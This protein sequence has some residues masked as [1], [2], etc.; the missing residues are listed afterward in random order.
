MIMTAISRKHYLRVKSEKVSTHGIIYA[1][2]FRIK[3]LIQIGSII[4]PNSL[5][6]TTSAE[7]AQ[8]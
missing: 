3:F 2:K 7:N 4:N 6:R 5:R 1:D 8:F